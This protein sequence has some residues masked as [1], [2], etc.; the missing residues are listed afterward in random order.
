MGHGLASHRSGAL[1]RVALPDDAPARVFTME[2]PA[3]LEYALRI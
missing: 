3:R 1:N 2:R